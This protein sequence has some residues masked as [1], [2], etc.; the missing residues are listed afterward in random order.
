MKKMFA[1][2]TEKA[3]R[4][5][6]HLNHLKTTISSGQCFSARLTQ[7]RHEARRSLH[8][9]IDPV[10]LEVGM[11]LGDVLHNLRASL[12]Y[13][14]W[15]LV[16]AAGGVPD[17]DTYFPFCKTREQLEKDL[18]KKSIRHAGSEVHQV[19]LNIIRPY[20]DGNKVL[21]ALHWMNIIDKHRVVLPLVAVGQL[22]GISFR[23]GG[24]M[25]ENA[26]VAVETGG[27]INLADSCEP[28]V[29]I[30]PGLPKFQVRMPMESGLSEE[31]LVPSL[32]KMLN[33]VHEI[34]AQVSEAF[35]KRNR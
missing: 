27:R 10:P 9:D 24:I 28:I 13:L 26:T 32:E 29:V 1:V 11:M 21:W 16:E 17:K 33:A 19:I 30:D 14:A 7:R 3:N 20:P 15:E 34:I 2:A 23:T 8:V 22:I 35:E 31:P 12:D 5:S 18:K 6:V 4:A 25:L